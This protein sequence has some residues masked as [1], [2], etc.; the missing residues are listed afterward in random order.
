MSVANQNDVLSVTE[1]YA[2]R[3]SN[4]AEVSHPAICL[5]PGFGELLQKALDRGTP[6][7]QAEVDIQFPDLN[8]EW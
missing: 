3:F 5:S 6:L 8:W 7:T 4:L 2:D 1:A